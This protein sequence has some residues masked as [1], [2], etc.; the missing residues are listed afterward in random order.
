MTA[1]L[2][3]ARAT[4]TG[5]AV[6]PQCM[7]KRLSAAGSQLGRSLIRGVPDSLPGNRR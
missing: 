1:P 6:T 5:K 4:D 3:I 2:L 7:A